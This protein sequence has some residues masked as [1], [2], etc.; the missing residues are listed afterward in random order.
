MRCSACFDPP[1]ADVLILRS[2]SPA[3][4]P[5][6]PIVQPAKWPAQTP[7]CLA[8]RVDAVLL[9][10]LLRVDLGRVTDRPRELVR[11]RGV[12]VRGE[13]GGFGPALDLQCQQC[14]LLPPQQA[15][16]V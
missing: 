5:R 8:A 1:S 9:R 4:I 2:Q 10:R 7:L 14:P 16:G 11:L 3:R 6:L 13:D 15:V 12:L